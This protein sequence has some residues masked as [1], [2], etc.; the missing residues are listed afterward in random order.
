MIAESSSVTSVKYLSIEIM[1]LEERRIAMSLDKR[2][3]LRVNPDWTGKICSDPDLPNSKRYVECEK[4]DM[5]DMNPVFYT[6][7]EASFILAI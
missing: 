7:W 3:I 2:R 4:T 1:L 5:N 6:Y